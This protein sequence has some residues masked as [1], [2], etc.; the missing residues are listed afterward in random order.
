MK[1]FFIAALGCGTCLFTAVPAMANNATIEASGTMPGTCEVGGANI[2][3]E[4]QAGS[5]YMSGNGPVSLSTNGKSTLSLSKPTLE[6]PAGAIDVWG[7]IYLQSQSSDPNIMLIQNSKYDQP[8]EYLSRRIE[9]PL[10]DNP[11][12]Y[13]FVSS[14]QQNRPL[15]AGFYRVTST[16]TCVSDI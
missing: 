13:V 11:T 9:A 2:N 1:R 7:N 5:G 8:V 3:L 6:A 12:V 16:L 4:G 10:T 14:D 15:P